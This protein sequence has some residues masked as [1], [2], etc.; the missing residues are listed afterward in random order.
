MN[1]ATQI[2]HLQ[3][4]IARAMIEMEAMKAANSQDMESQPYDE[5]AFYTLIDRHGIGQ[6]AV[7]EMLRE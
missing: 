7:A 5:N 4:S 2:V 6:D 1:Q 3:A